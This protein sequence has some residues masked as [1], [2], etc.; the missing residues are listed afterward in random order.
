MYKYIEEPC[1]LFITS[2]EKISILLSMRK[3]LHEQ[4]SSIT[5]LLNE[6]KKDVEIPEKLDS[7][8]FTVA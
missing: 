3:I 5:T 1:L 6:G 7:A 8:K 2:H 4:I